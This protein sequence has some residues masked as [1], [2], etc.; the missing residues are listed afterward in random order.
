MP[1]E[2]GTI[3]ERY[4]LLTFEYQLTLIT[5]EARHHERRAVGM[6]GTWCKRLLGS[7]KVWFFGNKMVCSF[8][9]AYVY[10]NGASGALRCW[11]H[12]P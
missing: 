1:F 5:S 8:N 4:V 2:V 6:F 3:I 11:P 9:W 7:S 12:T 10:L